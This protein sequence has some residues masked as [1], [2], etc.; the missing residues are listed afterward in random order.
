M[1]EVTLEYKASGFLLAMIKN[2]N[3]KKHL[4]RKNLSS[5]CFIKFNLP[6]D[7]ITFPKKK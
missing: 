3:K 4:Y 6:M 5:F 1:G 7:I 2:T